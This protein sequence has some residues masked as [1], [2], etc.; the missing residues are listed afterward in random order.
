MAKNSVFVCGECGNEYPKWQ[1]FCDHCQAID[2]MYEQKIEKNSV[3]KKDLNIQSKIYSLNEID[4]NNSEKIK[5]KI[6]ELDRVLQGGLG[7]GSFILLAGLPG[8]GK[9]TLL[10]NLVDKMKDSF[11]KTLY[12][13]GE[14][15]LGQIKQRAKRL[16]LESD[17][18]FD[19]LSETNLENIF[20][21]LNK[22]NY[23]FLI[24]DSIQTTYIAGVNGTAGG[25]SQVKGVTLELMKYT[26]SKNI[27]CII[28]GHVTKDGEI[29]GPKLLEHMVDTVIYLEGHKNDNIRFI[30]VQKNRFGPTDMVGVCKLSKLGI[31][32]YE[33][34]NKLFKKKTDILIP[35]V[36]KSVFLKGNRIFF[37]EIQTLLTKTDFGYPKRTSQGIELNKLQLMI[38]IMQKRLNI[39]LQNDDC[40]LKVIGD[41]RIIDSTVD[42]AVLMALV[43]ADAN[44]PISPKDIFL[45]EIGLTGEILE[46]DNMVNIVEQAEKFSIETIYMSTENQDIK[47]SKIKI[48]KYSL[49]EDLVKDYLEG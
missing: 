46:V 7:R 17:S 32:K 12:I 43:S 5:T 19:L 20:E 3:I 13:S 37:C 31:V 15:S 9:S 6:E 22:T 42:L 4:E 29:A 39:E 25:T 11:S 48:K 10:L 44:I 47:S 27:T 24:L 33:N 34:D 23:E 26:K 21:H 30:N 38:A 8:I 14:E 1:A 45:G 35:G 49:I 41:I 18:Y 28:V 16:E 40:F 2:S 36:S